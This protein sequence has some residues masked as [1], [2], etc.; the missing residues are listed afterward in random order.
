MGKPYIKSINL[1]ADSNDAEHNESSPR[2]RTNHYWFDLNKN[3]EIIIPRAEVNLIG[4]M[5]GIQML[6]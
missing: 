6:L 2:G 1:V 5:N 3:L 4:F